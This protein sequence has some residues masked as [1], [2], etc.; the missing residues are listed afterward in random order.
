MTALAAALAGSPELF[1][2]SIQPDGRTRLVRLSEAD[3]RAASFLD[4]RLA[5]RV[6][7]GGLATRA[8]IDAAVAELPVACDF[9]F[10]IGH[11]G[12]TLLARLLGASP[13]IFAVREP[14]VLRQAARGEAAPDRLEPLARLLSRVWRAE[15][16]ALVK[17]T[18]FVSELGPDMMDLSGEG[19][20]VL[21]TVRA[22]TFLAGILGGP[23]ARA[24]LPQAAPPRLE[25]LA[26]R[27]GGLAPRAASPG[28]LVAAVFAAE[29]LALAA[30]AE[31][32]PQRTVWLDFDAFL[33]DPRQKL[34]AV[35][36]HLTGEARSREVGAL[37]ASP[38][39]GRYAKAPEHPF[40]PGQRGATLRQSLQ[41]NGAEIAAGL[42]WL[43]GLTDRIPTLRGLI[44]GPPTAAP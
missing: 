16:R 18:S 9:I 26:R 40:G 31:R 15:Q 41:E 19:R 20:A 17:A 36:A 33:L 23:A 28:E 39:M 35:L 8:D 2:L 6:S 13:R 42:R 14:A 1:P 37:L 30:I 11:V 21:M 29:S 3:Y 25:R 27:L 34:G 43:S 24:E 7:E 12:S 32:F 38:D 22:Q 10:H 44:E 4:E 5:G